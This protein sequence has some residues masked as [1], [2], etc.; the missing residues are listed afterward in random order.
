MPTLDE[1]NKGAKQMNEQQKSDPVN[2]PAHYLAASIRLEPI[3]LTARLDSC[4]GQAIQYVFR[5]P[6]K[7][8]TREDLEKAIYY[9]NKWIEVNEFEVYANDEVMSL[10]NVFHK[11]CPNRLAAGV[12]DALASGHAGDEDTVW[13]PS[14]EVVFNDCSVGRAIDVIEQFLDRL[15]AKEK[16]HKER[17]ERQKQEELV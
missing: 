9:L 4:L 7:G 5:A 16:F 13:L 8:S 2:R 12:L 11:Y 17:I 1:T 15:D 3:E 10:F 14:N 6:Y